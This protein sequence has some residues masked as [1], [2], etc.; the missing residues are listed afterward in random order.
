[1]VTPRRVYIFLAVGLLC[2]S[3]SANIIRLGDASPVA[4][5]FWRLFIA[6]F[7]FVPLTGKGLIALARLTRLDLAV[8]VLGG[9]ALTTHFFS[10]IWAVQ[11]TTVANATLFLAINPVITATAAFL[12]FGER[13]GRK[14]VLAIALGLVGMCI[15][16]YNDLEFSQD[17]LLGD[18]LALLSSFLF[19]VYFMAAK[20]LRKILDARVYVTSV[21]GVAAVF[22][23][24]VLLVSDLPLVSYSLRT[25]V[26]F[27]LMALVP[28]MIGHTSLNTALRYMKAG[29]ISALTLVEPLL[30]GFVASLAW[31]ETI[32]LV[33]IAG[34]AL[35]CGSV[36]MV[37]TEGRKGAKG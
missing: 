23:F 6:T 2:L 31:G 13:A 1:M 12:F 27:C 8:L 28:T 16:G 33:S 4:I 22:S 5:A 34:Y 18:C 14:L 30:A 36:L 37:A 29:R 32:T 15:L 24:V 35:I 11:T 3:Q 26:C 19:T 7:L 9:F 10:W 20:R 25:W 17:H 21:Y